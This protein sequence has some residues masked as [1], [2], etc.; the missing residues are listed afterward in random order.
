LPTSV[1]YHFLNNNT[2][3]SIRNVFAKQFF[4]V[5]FVC[6]QN[7]MVTPLHCYTETLKNF[8]RFLLL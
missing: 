7:W 8:T 6:F 1:N 2:P 5:V 4:F 3:P